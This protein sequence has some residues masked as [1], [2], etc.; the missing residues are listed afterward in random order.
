MAS[1]IG[2]ELA[3]GAVELGAVA[4]VGEDEDAEGDAVVLE[5]E[6][7]DGLDGRLF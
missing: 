7:D 2:E 3:L 6:G 4:F 5:G 1:V